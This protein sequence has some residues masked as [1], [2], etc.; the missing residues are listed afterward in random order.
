VGD[1]QEPS[2][3]AEAVELRA[4]QRLLP[5]GE[6]AGRSAATDRF[7]V[8]GEGGRRVG[9]ERLVDGVGHRE[10][11][12]Q[13]GVDR[14]PERDR[15]LDRSWR[16]RGHHPVERADP[17]PDAAG[18]SDPR[19]VEMGRAGV[20]PTVASVLENSHARDHRGSADG[21]FIV[22]AP[23]GR[24]SRLSS[25]VER[26]TVG[27]TAGS[28]AAPVEI[29]RSPVRVRQPGPELPPAASSDMNRRSLPRSMALW[30]HSV[31]VAV[32]DRRRA[33]KWYREKLGF[34]VT[35]DDP[36][37]W[38]AVADRR[39]R[40]RIHLCEMGGVP[41]RPPRRSEVGNTG[42]LLYTDRPIR[43]FAGQLRKKGVRFSMP[44]KK[45]PWGWI[46]K[47]LDP[48]GNEFWLMP[49]S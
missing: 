17:G 4:P 33:A 9:R 22:R 23:L 15:G 25:V 38:T 45:F 20:P 43:A 10:Q 3:V 44:P 27:E 2:A 48:D 30:I 12:A 26:G 32:S 36:E 18:E 8:V 42:I 37:H 35:D 31:A 40:V 47:F 39:R 16:G 41:G 28:P 13:F 5:T 49:A 14:E 21:E 46:A 24:P 29:L 34:V 6:L 1:Q 19:R 7:D 11:P